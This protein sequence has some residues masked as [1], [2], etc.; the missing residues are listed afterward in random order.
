[1]SNCCQAKCNGFVMKII[2]LHQ[3]FNTPQM[4]GGTRSYEMARR[5]VSAGH[6]VHIVTS[7]RK[8]TESNAWVHEV[9]DGIN[10]HWL[11]IPYDNAM[12]Y[13]DRVR[14]FIKFAFHCGGKARSI[15]ADVVFATSTPLTIVVPGYYASRRLGCPMVFEVR[16]L[17]PE[18]PIAIGAL[19]NPIMK[20]S[21]RLFERFAYRSSSRVVALSPGMADGVAKAGYPLDRIH[22]VPNSCDNELFKPNKASSNRFRRA[23]PELGT[24]PIVLYAGTFGKINGVDFLVELAAKLLRIDPSVKFLAIGRGAEFDKVRSKAKELGVLGKNYFQYMSMPKEELVSAIHAADICTSLFVDIP[25]MENNSANKFFD[26]L[27]AGRPVAINYGGWH[28]DLIARYSIGIHLS[29]DIDAAA[30]SLSRFLKD[31]N[32]LQKAS[33]NARQLALEEFDRDRLSG[34]LIRVLQDAYDENMS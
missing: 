1:V 2:Y 29:R 26:A 12:S 10:V 6:E 15:G 13:R 8:P 22:V 16:D 4:A 21:M 5:M 7:W 32:K 17:W 18:L 24:G 3:Y 11:P 25:E 27:A 34:K 28:R 23:H 14:A 19:K 31:G 20:M 9:I 30:A 33:K